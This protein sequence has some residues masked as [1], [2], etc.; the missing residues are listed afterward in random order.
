MSALAA[1]ADP[2]WS[3]P[4]P[5]PS[6]FDHVLS[7]LHLHD[8]KA[9]FVLVLT[10]VIASLIAVAFHE[11]GHAL[12]ARAV[13][14]PIRRMV[15]GQGPMVRAWRWRG[16]ACE[17]RAVPLTGF[18]V[19][20][21]PFEFR[22]YAMVLV[23]VGGVLGNLVA[24]FCIAGLGAAGLLAA[25]PGGFLVLTQMIAIVGNLW[26][27][28]KR[29]GDRWVSSDGLQLVSLLRRPR[30]RLV[31]LD[32]DRWR[33]GLARGSKPRMLWPWRRG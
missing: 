31:P 14:I 3:S 12:C 32:T 21:E 9:A 10:F 25:R 11:L 28:R 15:I 30:R 33:S 2:V 24:I 1:A 5:E 17:L 26:P 19:I 8:V 23:L 29:L 27:Y 7:V 16:T 4:P 20:D 18:V 22:K 13:G 6:S